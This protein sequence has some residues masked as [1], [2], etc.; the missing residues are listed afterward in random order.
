M[1]DGNRI[2]QAEGGVTA[3]AGFT[4]GAVAAGVRKKDR[5][6]VALVLS[7]TPALAAGVFTRN[8]VKAHCVL[9]GRAKVRGGGPLRGVLVN[10]GC[11]N[12]CTGPEGMADLRTVIRGLAAATGTSARALLMASTGVI[13]E[14]L[15]A[16]RIVNA[17]PAL[18]G[19]LSR[20]GHADAARA[21]MTTDTVPKE[22][23]L[24]VETARGVITVG[25]M[26]K[27]AGMINPSM[28]TMLSFLTTDALIGDHAAWLALLREAVEGSFNRVDA[29][30]DTSTNDMVVA[31]AGGR[32]GIDPF[33]L[34]REEFAQA[35][36][37]VCD[38][39]ARMIVRD[40]E[41]ATKV[42]TVA[43]LGA[44]SGREAERAART[45][46]ESL[47]VKTAIHGQDPNWGRILAALGR[48]GARFHPDRVAISLNGL[49]L[50]L[51]GRRNPLVSE[52]SARAAL[53]PDEV[54]VEAH[55]N[56]GSSSARIHTADLTADYIR[57]N[58]SYR[59]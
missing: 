29:D 1:A 38:R 4:A 31:L 59:S 13:G 56:A 34:C 52:E 41:G 11:A 58:A 55:L 9:D 8:R 27:G 20:E 16:Y 18:A 10:S 42:F 48:S 22:F 45:V 7:E 35:V 54:L 6:D 19:A 39:L 2:V 51:E 49:P 43:V 33:A 24:T 32:S 15:P 28:A 36:R 40:T 23:A 14:R 21:I 30:G 53:L 44:R 25:G 26:A 3:A 5:L 57:I 12:A 50:V 46:A 37:G 17:L 47:L